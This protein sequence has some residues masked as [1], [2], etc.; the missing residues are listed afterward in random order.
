M[1][2]TIAFA[3]HV[4]LTVLW[5]VM[6]LAALFVAY[7][8]VARARGA[9]A[10]GLAFLALILALANPLIVH[11]NREPLSDVAVIVVDR[12]QSMQIGNR[13][14]EAESAATEL[15]ARL[16]KQPNLDV[17]TV[18]VTTNPA[19]EDS[20]T[21][22]FAA[23]NA[24]LADVPPSRVAGAFLITD[25]EVHDTPP[26]SRVAPVQALIVGKRGE[27]DRK[28]TVVDSTR[29][30]IVG[31]KAEIVV[32]VDDLGGENRGSA[33]VALRI[34]GADAGARVVP[35]GKNTPVE[36]PVGHEGESVVEVEAE[37]GTSELT[38]QNNRAVVAINGV[39][40]RLR[41]LLGSGEPHAGERVWR[42]LL[43]GD[44]SV[45]LVHFT[46]LRPPEKQDETPLKELSLIVFPTRELFQ[47]KLDGFDLV[48]FDRYS[49]HGILP[50]A[51]FQNIAGYVYEGG[52]LLV[53]SGPEFAGP[54]SIY[55]TPLTSVLPA[56]PT[57]EVT[58]KPFKPAVTPLGLSHPVT[59]DLNGANTDKTP[60]SWGRWFRLIGAQR[61][62]GDVVMS[63]PGDK[64]LLVLDRIGA[65]RVAELLSDQDWLWAR[66]F[67]GGG[68]AAELL[69]RTAHWLMKE[70]ELE[71]EKLTA[72][73]AGG[74]LTVERRTMAAA[75]AAVTMT[76][77]SGKQ[78]AVA[79]TKS[80]PGIWRGTAKADALG[81]Y[82]VTDGKL[83]AVAAAGPL[84]PKEVADMRATDAVLAGVTEQSGGAARWLSDGMPEIRRVE[85]GRRMAGEGWMG[86]AKN[87]A[88]R[89]TSVDQT[90]L[91]PAWAAVIL[92]LGTLMLAWRQE[93][94]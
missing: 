94:R 34:D 20:G 81:L 78:S 43:K 3:P 47:E 67:E 4:P 58:T 51:Y 21:Q 69:R 80:E 18:A 44:P 36:V 71:E 86:I 29:Y 92:L 2:P 41:G 9:W 66:G 55:R 15:K 48:I 13:R 52:A 8:F 49:E 17:R 46:I 16:A 14:A 30:A 22:A 27:R 83:S 11:E 6:G 25:G 73:I 65:G 28:L 26:K 1:I 50:L 89:V 59:R 32:R 7:G 19:G 76:D 24:A 91:L 12:S 61:I 33:K 63:G 56:Q 84:N 5:V 87:E 85:R 68:P 77:P 53:S 57:G 38:L 82:R 54:M 88:S 37:P 35:L 10:R 70:P 74:D 72:S 93:G 42:S 40:D 23:L 90:P 64:P 79:L 62:T 31:Q 39:R 60:P 75:P 45:D